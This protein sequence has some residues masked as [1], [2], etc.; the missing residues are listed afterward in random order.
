MFVSNIDIVETAPYINGFLF[1]LVIFFSGILI[2]SFKYKTKLY[3][4]IVLILIAIS[5]SLIEIY[6]MLWSETLFILLCLVFFLNFKRYF[7]THSLLSLSIVAMV[8][9]IA[10][11]T[12]YAGITLLATG[13]LLI[14]F[15]KNLSWPRKFS[16]GI[17][18]GCISVSLVFINLIRNIWEVGL[19]TGKRQE[20]T[21]LLSKNIEYS[22]KVFTDWFSFDINNQLFLKLIFI[23]VII[24]FISFFIRNIKHWKAYYTYENILVAFFVVYVLFI[25]VSSTISRYESI[26][27]RLLAPAFIPL[28]LVSTCQIPK[29]RESLSKRLLRWIIWGFSL[30]IGGLFVYSFIM[31][32][33]DNLEYM[34]ETGIP[35]YSEDTWQKSQLV[36]YLRK[37]PEIFKMN[38]NVYSNHCQAVYFLTGNQCATLPEMAYNED[39]KEFFT[40]TSCI[41]IWFNLDNNPDLLNLKEISKIMH[42]QPIKTF[43]DGTIYKLSKKQ[44]NKYSD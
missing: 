35:G 11:D 27:N 5:P 23:L 6:T 42:L 3:K 7:Q 31:I 30:G 15:D 32:N 38:E 25:I 9:S 26:N 17:Y 8:S 44:N 10:F 13:E 37:D 1:A 36:T 19:A 18:F 24:L 2:E 43:R 29:W 39:V 16:H 14:L 40:N 12:R 28:L 34:L 4:R 20:G 22:G 21:T 33:K 41:L